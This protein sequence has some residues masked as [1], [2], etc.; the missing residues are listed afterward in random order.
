MGFCRLSYPRCFLPVPLPPVCCSAGVPCAPD[1]GVGVSPRSGLRRGRPPPVA[2]LTAWGRARL[3]EVVPSSR[4]VPPGCLFCEHPVRRPEEGDFSCRVFKCRVDADIDPEP[5]RAAGQDLRLLPPGFQRG[6]RPGPR[7]AGRGA[8]PEAV[9]VQ[10]E[11]GLP[12]AAGDRAAGALPESEPCRPGSGV[13]WTRSATRRLPRQ[14][15]DA[16]SGQGC[17]SALRGRCCTQGPPP[18]APSLLMPFL[19]HCTVGVPLLPLSRADVSP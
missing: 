18:L 11:A 7:A 17:S 3:A 8:R 6:R 10:R 13:A 19:R 2:A 5:P 12:H 9:G 4:P 1:L 14:R 15:S 16:A